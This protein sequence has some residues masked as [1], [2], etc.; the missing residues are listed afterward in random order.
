MTTNTMH[1]S[2]DISSVN[3]AW[4][5][6]VNR[7]IRSRL[8]E[9]HPVQNLKRVIARWLTFTASTSGDIDCFFILSVQ[10]FPIHPLAMLRL[11]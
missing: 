5:E 6:A 7:V 10:C 1:C 9:V 4:T 8:R 3:V 11:S 2:P